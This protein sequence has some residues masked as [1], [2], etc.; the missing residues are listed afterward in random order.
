MRKGVI[1][2]LL[3]GGIL[4]IALGIVIG[5]NLPASSSQ[6][7]GAVSLLVSPTTPPSIAQEPLYTV[8]KVI[9]GDTIDVLINEKKEIVRLIGIDTPE[10]VDPRKPVQCFGEEAS[11]KAK[12]LLIGE[13]VRLESDPTQSDRDKYHRL[14]RYVFLPDGTFLNL[15]L[16]Q[17]GF[18]HEYTYNSPYRYQKEFKGAQK[19]AQEG[20]KGLWAD[21]VCTSLPSLG[22]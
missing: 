17:E 5:R 6:T 11:Q 16:I 1:G 8:L 4:F 3:L 15:L 10:V 12:Q 18:A 14:L 20:K 13:Q 22:K 7:L 19:K 9:D 2:L 21:G